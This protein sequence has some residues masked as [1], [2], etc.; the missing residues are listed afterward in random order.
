MACTRSVVTDLAC[1]G[2]LG[3]LKVQCVC[4]CG[5]YAYVWHVVVYLA[6][7]EVLVA[8]TGTLGRAGG[9][10]VECSVVR[11]IWPAPVRVRWGSERV[12]G[13]ACT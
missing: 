9:A 1:T 3:K 6:D 12:S 13:I 10:C 7:S 4:V 5:V 2:T 8:C 11:Q